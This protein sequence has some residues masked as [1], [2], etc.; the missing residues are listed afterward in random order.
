MVRWV[1][2]SMRPF[3]IAEDRGFKCL[4]KTGRPEQYTPSRRTVAR[5]VREV[6]K[7][8]RKRIAAMLQV[9]IAI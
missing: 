3:A 5:D 9:S 4:M 2:E 7:N 8:V 1:T 6:F